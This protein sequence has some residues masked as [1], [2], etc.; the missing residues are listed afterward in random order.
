MSPA[1]R[2]YTL[3]ELREMIELFDH[4]VAVSREERLVA[5]NEAMLRVTGHSR[6]SMEG[7][8]FVEFLPPEERRRLMDLAMNE[9]SG[10]PL[11]PTNF[12]LALSLSGELIPFQISV[13]ALPSAEPGAPDFAVASCMVVHEQR[14]ELQLAERLGEISTALMSQRSDEAIRATAVL[15]FERA[16]IWSGFYAVDPG[17]LRPW[18]LAA[19]EAPVADAVYA[20]DAIYEHRPV[21]AAGGGDG[22]SLVYVPIRRGAQDEVLL[23]RGP[24]STRSTS[25]LKLFGEQLSQS[26]DNARLISDLEQGHQ[27]TRLL[28]ELTRTTA[29]ALEMERILGSAAD[30]TVRLLDATHCFI[31]LYDDR[32]QAL[33]GAAGS[34]LVREEA[35]R[36]SIPLSLETVTGRAAVQRRPVAIGDLD[37]A[38]GGYHQGYKQ[39]FGAKAALAV[40]M[41]SREELIGVVLIVDKRPRRFDPQQLELAQA[42]AGQ[43]AMSVANARLFDSLRQSYETLQLTRAEM[44]KRERLAALG[45]LSAVV[46]HEV[47]N[48]LGVIFNAVG[49]LRKLMP[50][51]DSQ[52]LLNILSEESDRLNRLVG[53][54]LD[55]ARPPE[56]SKQVEDLGR[57][58]QDALEVA[59]ADPSLAGGTVRVTS[60]VE[61]GLPPIPMDGRQ[62]RQALVNVAVNAMQ[63]M[64]RGG[65]LSVTARRDGGAPER[66]LR[67]DIS[68]EGPGISPEVLPRIFEPF[69]TT[70]AQGTGLGLAVVKRI[71]EDH[72]GTVE[73]RSEMGRGTT[74]TLRLPLAE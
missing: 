50:E 9:R 29:H 23:L 67:I 22:L 53:E 30:F 54:L 28:L 2:R 57:V 62:L 32:E 21:F 17:Q 59:R 31:L 10:Q 33:R 58:I 8:L 47:R 40:P 15:A 36:V 48:P 72:Q 60:D 13:R 63:S 65:V 37:A 41:I 52:V 34:A 6:A 14:A 44:V 45:E 4:P 39:H 12:I 18:L 25:V 19:G 7:R 26:F 38:S 68:D 73:V 61:P 20:F 42:S 5:V 43:L 11:V 66:S 27:E 70:K 49:T 1:E 64:P 24:I 46:A 56:L 51:G 71:I 16:G 3:A 74:F 35:P 69:F 55:F